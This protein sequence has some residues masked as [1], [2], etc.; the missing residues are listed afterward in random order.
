LADRQS[1]LDHW[2]LRYLYT[3]IKYGYLTG[4]RTR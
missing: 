4:D 2:V 1:T 3:L